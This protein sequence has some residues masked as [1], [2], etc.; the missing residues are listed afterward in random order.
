MALADLA[1]SSEAEAEVI[2][3]DSPEG[4]LHSPR[5]EVVII[6]DSES[7]EASLPPIRKR[8]KRE[9][10]VDSDSQW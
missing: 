9:P 3:L 5:R 10:L 4:V 8:F 2:L 7:E 6:S 1:S